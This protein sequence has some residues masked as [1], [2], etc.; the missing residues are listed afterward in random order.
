[1]PAVLYAPSRAIRTFIVIGAVASLFSAT[2]V[3]RLRVTRNN[4]I[5]RYQACEQGTRKDCQG[6]LFWVLAGLPDPTVAPGTQ[7]SVDQGKRVT[8]TSDAAPLLTSLRPEG[9]TPQGQGYVI[10]PGTPVNLT[11]TIEGADRVEVRFWASG[12]APSSLVGEKS[13][14][15]KGMTAIKDKESTYEAAFDWT[16]TRSGELEVRAYGPSAQEE[17]TS[18]IIPVTVGPVAN[19][20]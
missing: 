11:A 19:P 9:F 2:V 15:L 1:M 8:R 16:E 3:W 7:A 4:E 6:S 5:L 10:S 17:M 18:L 12:E 20:S 13:A 14:L